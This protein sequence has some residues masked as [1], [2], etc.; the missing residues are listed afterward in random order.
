MSG[1]ANTREAQRSEQSG[2]QSAASVDS[3][4]ATGA[5][6]Q[7]AYEIASR[8]LGDKGPPEYCIVLDREYRYLDFA[9]P[10]YTA[11]LITCFAAQ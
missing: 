11:S 9:Y 5:A 1:G 4:T 3:G 2:R 7:D 10:V 6:N 8:M